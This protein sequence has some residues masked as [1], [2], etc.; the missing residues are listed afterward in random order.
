MRRQE[1]IRI[2][3]GQQQGQQTGSSLK[4]QTHTYSHSTPR[5]VRTPETQTRTHPGMLTATPTRE[6]RNAYQQVVDQNPVVQPHQGTELTNKEERT[7][8]THSNGGKS[9]RT[10]KEPKKLDPPPSTKFKTFGFHSHGILENAAKESRSTVLGAAGVAAGG[11]DLRGSAHGGYGRCTQ[12]T[13][14]CTV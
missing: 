11:A 5:C 8:G 2:K 4:R 12:E 3:R 14:I 6:L 10:Q 9:Q 7:A 1:A 13:T